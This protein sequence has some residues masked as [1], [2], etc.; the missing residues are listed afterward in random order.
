MLF[1]APVTQ[2]MVAY[3]TPLLTANFEKGVFITM[4]LKHSLCASLWELVATSEYQVSLFCL[5]R[6]FRQ[7]WKQAKHICNYTCNIDLV[8]MT[9]CFCIW[10]CFILVKE[11]CQSAFLGNHWTYYASLVWIF[12]GRHTKLYYSR[13]LTLKFWA[14]KWCFSSLV[15]TLVRPNELDTMGP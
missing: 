14:M 3:K 4:F 5:V 7:L 11:E 10:Q 9:L 13:G 1:Y 6:E 12:H 2:Y 8:Y 15:W